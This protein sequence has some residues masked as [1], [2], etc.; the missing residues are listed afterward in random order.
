MPRKI[1]KSAEETSANSETVLSKP[2]NVFD[3]VKKID[4]YEQSKPTQMSLFE[5]LLPQERE[6]SNSIELYDFIPKYYWG[7]SNR[8]NGKFLEQL[9]R[10]FECRG[11]HYRVKIDPAKISDRDG[12]TRDYY[13]S[14]RE[15]LVE[16][17]LR[18]FACEGQGLFL[19]DQAGVTFTL[20][21]IHHELKRLGHTYSIREIKDALLICAKANITV[22]S[23]DGK[24]ILVSSLFETLGLQTR[25]D[26]RGQGEKTKAF[27]RFNSLVTQSIKQQ[28]FRQLNYDKAMSYKSVIARQLHKRMAHHYPQASFNN[29]YHFLLSTI[30]RDFGLTEYAQLRDNLR[31]VQAALEEMKQMEVIMSYKVQKTLDSQR[32]NKLI[33]AKFVLIPDARFIS[34]VIKANR[35]QS[36]IKKI[37]G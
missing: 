29:P 24:A 31:D 4:D 26:W 25:E 33:D 34:E 17:A 2:A 1:K 28:T 8:I 27:V 35:R 21:Q 15:E 12:I 18:K 3:G 14:K 10:E 5:M 13:P 16:D 6:F 20:Y 37:I 9:E 19:D 32:R 23:E 36:E 30:I 7:K 22:S 11:V